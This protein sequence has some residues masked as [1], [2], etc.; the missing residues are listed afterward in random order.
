MR[1]ETRRLREIIRLDTELSTVQDLDILLERI[2]TE[3]RKIL[4]ADAGTIYIKDKTD[5]IFTL[6]T[7]SDGPVGLLVADMTSGGEVRGYC[8]FDE[9]RLRALATAGGDTPSARTQMGD[10]YMAFTVD[11][12][13]HTERYQGIVEL[14]GESLTEV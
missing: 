3:A 9:A 11:Q 2:L 12:G 4:S 1:D 7:K 5:L 6:Q 10:G 8:E 14:S 13:A